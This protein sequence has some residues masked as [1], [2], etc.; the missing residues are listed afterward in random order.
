MGG[1]KERCTSVCVQCVRDGSGRARRRVR[2]EFSGGFSYDVVG[3]VCVLRGV[4][5]GVWGVW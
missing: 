3:G 1:E 5:C 2:R 4:G